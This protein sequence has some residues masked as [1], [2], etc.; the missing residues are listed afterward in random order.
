MMS[1]TKLKQ[2]SH[3]VCYN[4]AVGFVWY[5]RGP[6]TNAKINMD[7]PRFITWNSEA[8]SAFKK[9]RSAV[10]WLNTLGHTS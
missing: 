8:L 2:A 4:L 10:A 7:S 9:R 6:V 5:V 1:R 3:K